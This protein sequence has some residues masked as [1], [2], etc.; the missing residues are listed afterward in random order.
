MYES[1][2]NMQLK[3]LLVIDEHKVG[4]KIQTRRLVERR[5]GAETVLVS[6]RDLPLHLSATIKPEEVA[7]LLC[8]FE[9]HTQHCV[10]DGSSRAES[11]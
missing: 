10:E 3:S 7:R 1:E 6:Q 11:K 8:F 4:K 5:L 9:K 2:W